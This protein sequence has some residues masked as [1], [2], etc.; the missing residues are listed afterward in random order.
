MSKSERIVELEQKT[1][2]AEETYDMAKQRWEKDQAIYKQ[3][4]E[5]LELQLKEERNK[6]EEQKA[7]HD[8]MMRNLQMR[9]RDSVIGK[10]ESS[11]RIQEIKEAHAQEYQEL[12]AKYDNIRRRMQEQID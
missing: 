7:T 2:L 11:R 9:E 10:E 1:K 5:F 8:Q 12:E 6:N 3:K 4:Q